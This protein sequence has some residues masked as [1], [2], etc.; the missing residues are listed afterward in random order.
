MTAT[1]MSGGM[2]Q[3]L[4]HE[5]VNDATIKFHNTL[6]STNVSMWQTINF[7]TRSRQQM[8]SLFFCFDS[9]ML[10]CYGHIYSIEISFSLYIIRKRIVCTIYTVF[11][12]YAK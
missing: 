4:G 6:T 9:L 1:I 3:L 2:C 11:T 7:I 8:H 5:G 10:Y 12:I